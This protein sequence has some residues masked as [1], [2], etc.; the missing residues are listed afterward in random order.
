MLIIMIRIDKRKYLY[1]ALL[2]VIILSAVIYAGRGH[3]YKVN[4]YKSGNG[5]GYDITKNN[6]SY[7][8]QPYMPVVEG[9]VPFSSKQSAKK[10]AR[11]AVKKIRNHKSPA[12]TREE[13]KA[14]IRK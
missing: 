7:I 14:I 3:F 11:L 6:K 13:L 4:L 12:I 9:Q 8:H 1:F 5:W 2:L 10:T